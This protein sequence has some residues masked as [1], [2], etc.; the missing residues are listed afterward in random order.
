MVVDAAGLTPAIRR[1]LDDGIEAL[2]LELT[3]AQVDAL[4][5]YLGLLLRWNK[6]YN[7]TAVREPVAMVQ[8]HLLDSLAVLPLFTKRGPRV[9]DVG[10]GAGLPGAVLAIAIPDQQFDQ[11]DSNGQKCRVQF[12]VKTELGVAN[13]AV[14]H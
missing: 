4:C 2:S 10:T 8:R 9:I 1:A 14:R 6:A 12:Q 3:P 11:H 7:L 13:I 5:A